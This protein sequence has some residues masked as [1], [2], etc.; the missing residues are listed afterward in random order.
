MCV[1]RI[2]FH[3]M[4]GTQLG[5]TLLCRN[6]S[7][8]KPEKCNSFGAYYQVL[9]LLTSRS[10]FTN[11]RIIFMSMFNDIEWTKKGNTE[12]TC[13]QNAKGVAAFTTQSKQGHWCCFVASVR[14]NVLERK[15]QRASRKMRYYRIEDG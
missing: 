4:I 7:I 5:R 13:L 9:P 10:I 14:K 15:L 3:L 12:T 11:E 8:W 2:Q 6:K 1:A